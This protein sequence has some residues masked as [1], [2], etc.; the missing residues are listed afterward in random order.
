MWR[1]LVIALETLVVMTGCG[2]GMHFRLGPT[3]SCL[4]QRGYETSV[5]DNWIFKPTDGSLVVEFGR[6]YVA[7]NFGKDE[8]EAPSIRDAA[9]QANARWP[10]AVRGNV[11]YVWSVGTKGRVK[12]AVDCLRG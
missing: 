2:S 6:R 1:L 12:E 7:L 4:D 3:R 11:A 9:L 10:I 8:R 5:E